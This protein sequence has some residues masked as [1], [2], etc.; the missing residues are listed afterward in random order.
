MAG[1]SFDS[2][3]LPDTERRPLR[4]ACVVNSLRGG[5]AE[6]VISRLAE[7]L[8]DRGHTIGMIT[9]SG[10]D[11][12]VHHLSP[13]IARYALSRERQSRTY[14]QRARNSAGRV[15]ALTLVLRRF[16]PQAIVSFIDATNV[17]ALLANQV[18]RLP[19][20]I[21]ER[22][23]PRFHPVN[24]LTTRL[25]SLLYGTADALVLQ[26][27]ATRAWANR[28][29]FQPP[30]YVVP[31]PISAPMSSNDPEPVRFQPFIL[32]IGRLARQKGF[33]TLIRAFAQIRSNNPQLRLV[34]LGEGP[35]R[36]PLEQLCI[37]LGVFEA[38]HMP[39]YR[40]TGPWLRDALLFVLSSRYEG[41]P[42]SL[43]EAM[44]AGLPI[45]ATMCPSGPAEML[46]DNESGTLVEVENVE[47]LGGAINRLAGDPA[48]RAR[49][50]ERARREAQTRFAPSA[51]WNAWERIV[52]D[53][54][55]HRSGPKPRATK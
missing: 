15:G 55:A 1:T 20:V 49:Y 24:A 17:Y 50:G 30:T 27:E 11:S 48:L 4:I 53:A 36:R 46:V 37:S 19:I 42:N 9:F 51:V 38:V 18:L 16:E 23:D 43:G 8:A 32:A 45:V 29:R 5:G 33:D 10:E 21:S 35:E 26:T 34:I 25:R 3:A 52:A 2:A 14:L 44:S 12:D 40:N 31:N 28:L 47:A 41:F 6:L 39:G 54:I 22:I 13:R 7:A